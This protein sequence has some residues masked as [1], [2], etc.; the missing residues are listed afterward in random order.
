MFKSVCDEK[1]SFQDMNFAPIIIPTLCRAETFIPCIESL[2]Q[3]IGSDK[4][5]VYIALDYPLKDSHWEG[6]N[7]ILN[8]ID[9]TRFPF[10]SFNVIKRE[11]NY[12]VGT[13]NSNVNVA[14]NMLWEK[15]DRLI[16]SE[17]DNVFSPNFL[18]FINKGLDK[19]ENDKS[20]DSICGYLNYNGIKSDKNTFFR[21]PHNFSAWGYATWKDRIVDRKKITTSYFR[22]TLS[23][24]NLIKMG[25]LGRSRFLAYL[26]SMCPNKY[27]RISDVNLTTYMILENKYQIIPTTSLVR[28]I[29]VSSGQNFSNCS[30][31]ISNL[32]LKQS[33]SNDIF[34]DFIGTGFEYTDDN[35]KNWVHNEKLFHEKYHWITWDI[36]I[37]QTIRRTIKIILGSFGWKP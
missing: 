21:C 34:F 2:T 32:Y 1:I 36:I 4:T 17:D 8:Y 27:V 6:Y 13:P 28:N 16:F 11:C 9:S 33:I 23:F 15:Y 3:C 14:F 7:K 37:K 5:E 12:G 29:G 20:V 24:K 22:K 25:N 31:E 10:K 26:V 19:F 30:E 35:I 18:V